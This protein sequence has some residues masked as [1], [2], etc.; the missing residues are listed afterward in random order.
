MTSSDEILSGDGLPKHSLKF[1]I[2]K[3]ILYVRTMSHKLERPLV[4][5]SLPPVTER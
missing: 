4:Q 5:M 2:K 3:I 1:K